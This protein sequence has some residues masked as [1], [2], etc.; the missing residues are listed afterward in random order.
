MSSTLNPSIVGQV[1]KS[2]NAVLYRALAGTT[3]DEI[4]WIT[5]VLAVGVGGSVDRGTHV[6]HVANVA[7][8]EPRAVGA[9]VDQLILAELLVP[10]DDQLIVSRTG[11]EFVEKVRAETTPVVARAY[12]GI[13]SDDL[14]IT[15]RVLTEI[16]NNL[17]AELDTGGRASL[18]A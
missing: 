17:C 3:V 12:A 15:A 14:A 16:T 6:S 2:L 10:E 13:A 18:S 4:Q 1:E 5:L 7:R 8:F 11:R 9:A